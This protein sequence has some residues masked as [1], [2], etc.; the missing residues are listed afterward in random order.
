VI[1]EWQRRQ[2]VVLHVEFGQVASLR[3]DSVRDLV[4]HILL[5]VD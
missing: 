2:P 1:T 4:D 5:H 3:E